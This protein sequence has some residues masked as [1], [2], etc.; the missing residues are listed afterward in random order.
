MPGGPTSIALPSCRICSVTTDDLGPTW[1]KRKMV[2]LPVWQSLRHAAFESKR[3]RLVVA[4][5]WL[6]IRADEQDGAFQRPPADHHV[7]SKPCHSPRRSSLGR[8]GK[9]LR[10]L[11]VA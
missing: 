11:L 6:S 3:E 1:T 2:H 7:G 5:E 9:D 10:M 8:H 4:K